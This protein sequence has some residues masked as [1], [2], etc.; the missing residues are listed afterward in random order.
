[1]DRLTGSL[2]RKRK[3]E[4]FGFSDRALIPEGKRIPKS[5]EGIRVPVCLFSAC[6][7]AK[8][9]NGAQFLLM[10]RK[11]LEKLLDIWYTKKDLTEKT[12]A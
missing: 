1:M 11:I 5:A 3:A 10:K 8:S 12:G 9:L 6:K 4:I 2:C 7:R